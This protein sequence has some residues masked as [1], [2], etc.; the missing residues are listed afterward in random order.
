MPIFGNFPTKYQKTENAK[1]L[2]MIKSTYDQNFRQIEECQFLRFKFV[3]S[4]CSIYIRI[5]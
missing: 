2:G 1:F 5:K 4:R 3:K